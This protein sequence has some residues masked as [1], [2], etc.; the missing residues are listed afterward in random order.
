MLTNFVGF[1]SVESC[2]PN[3]Q[4]KNQYLLNAVHMPAANSQDLVASLEYYNTGEYTA[5][6]LTFTTPR[7]VS[8]KGYVRALHTV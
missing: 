1:C 6:E 4:K 8:I 2:L 5:E 7:M 3:P